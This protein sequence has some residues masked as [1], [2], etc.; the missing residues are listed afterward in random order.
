MSVVGNKM[1][2][3]VPPKPKPFCAPLMSV[4]AEHTMVSSLCLSVKAAEMLWPCS[5]VEL[6]GRK[7]PLN[8]G[9][10]GMVLCSCSPLSGGTHPPALHRA[11]APWHCSRNLAGCCLGTSWI[12]L[13]LSVGMNELT[14][15]APVRSWHRWCCS[16]YMHWERELRSAPL[17]APSLLWCHSRVPWAR[18][19][20]GL[21]SLCLWWP[22]PSQL[23]Q[24]ALAQLGA[25]LVLGSRDVGGHRSPVDLPPL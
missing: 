4:S 23:Q 12:P 9:A 20:L 22:S 24:V 16:R 25:Q 18:C 13:L 7:V 5:G 3:K 11:G 8:P 1:V 14:W 10:C 21:P 17:W 19:E 15:S 2:S 6:S